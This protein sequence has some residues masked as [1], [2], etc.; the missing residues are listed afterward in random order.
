MPFNSLCSAVK[1]VM[2]I[3]MRTFA[4]FFLSCS[5]CPL[6]ISRLFDMHN[7]TWFHDNSFGPGVPLGHLHSCPPL[8]SVSLE[9][10]AHSWPSEGAVPVNLSIIMDE[11]LKHLHWQCM[12]LQTSREHPSCQWAS[13]ESFVELGDKSLCWCFPSGWY[14][15]TGVQWTSKMRQSPLSASR[16]FFFFFV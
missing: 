5:D 9:S 4:M 3:I 10:E 14:W 15:S 1:L 13:P 6:I 16:V 2:T 11:V 7:W 8:S 12:A